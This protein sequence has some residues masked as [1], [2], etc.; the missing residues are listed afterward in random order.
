MQREGISVELQIENEALHFE[1]ASFFAIQT[2]YRLRSSED[3]EFPQLMIIEIDTDW[4][5]TLSRIHELRSTS[6]RTQIFVTASGT[7]AEVLLN[8]LRAGVQ[9]FLPQPLQKEDLCNAL[10]RF[11]ERYRDSLPLLAKRGK[12]I[13]VFGSKGGVGTTTL[14]VNL[15]VSLQEINPASSVAL[16]DLDLHFG[17][18]ALF[19][20]IEPTYT[21]KDIML[22]PSRLDETFLTGTL[23]RHPSG[24]YLLPAAEHVEEMSEW[25]LECIEQSLE[26]LQNMFDYVILDCGHMLDEI[27][28]TALNRAS[29][30]LIVSTLAFPVVRNTKRLVTLLSD[31][32]YPTENM[33]IIVNRYK[34]KHEIALRDFEECLKTELFCTI[35]NDYNTVSNSINRGTAFSS[36]HKKSKIAKSIK[37]LA[38]KLSERKNSKSLFSKV[39]ERTK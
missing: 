4:N 5:K 14:A 38:I 11:E 1:L 31:L 13:N 30:L 32:N 10:K 2:G 17:D 24:L 33:K 25:T 8:M 28:V 9:E 35:P 15:A 34:S 18:V 12:L 6:P 36:T 20:D 16:V 21:F 19:L 23:S 39:F 37:K 27:T 26:L 29:T 22:D 3:T 7:D